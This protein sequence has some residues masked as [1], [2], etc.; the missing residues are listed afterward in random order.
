M[1]TF[2]KRKKKKSAFSKASARAL[3]KGNIILI[4]RIGPVSGSHNEV[5]GENENF[6]NANSVKAKKD[7][8]LTNDQ[9]FKD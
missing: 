4:N 7:L 9:K 8:S 5:E 1:M 2:R 6:G 3:R